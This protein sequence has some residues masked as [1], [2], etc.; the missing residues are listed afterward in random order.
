MEKFEYI[1]FDLGGVLVELVGVPKILEWMNWSVDQDE[2]NRMWLF[3]SAVR[4]FEMGRTSA[5]EFAEEIISEFKF[6]VGPEDFIKEFLYFPKG[7]HS[8]TKELLQQLSAK[9]S[10]ACLSNTNELH[11]NRLCEEDCIENYFS[12][13][14]PSHKTGFMKPDIEAFQHVIKS[15]ACDAG[16]IL[17]LDDNQVNIEAAILAGMKAVK[18]NGFEDVKIKLQELEI[19]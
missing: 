16:K 14:F 8:G 13:N 3:S 9:Y 18:V 12:Y 11:W 4:N 10:L 15:L 17:F 6:S 2:L 7:L 1:L 5:L 19:I